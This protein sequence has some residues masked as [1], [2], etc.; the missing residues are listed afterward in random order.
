M[1]GVHVDAKARTA[2]VQGGCTW[3]D[4]DRETQVF[5]LAA[6]GG[7]VSTTGVAGL[8]LG[9]GLGYLRRKHGLTIDN[10]ISVD[11]V[12]VDGALRTASTVEN[13]ELFWGIRGGGGNFG[14][15]TSFEF[16]LHPVGP[17]V[18]LCNPWY[19][20]DDAAAILSKFAAIMK[21]APDEFS[22]NFFFWTIPAVV[23]FPE[24]HHGKRVA[25]IGGVHSGSLEE[26]ARFIQPLREL[27]QPLLDMSG[28]VPWTGVQAAFDPF[29][30]KREAP[31]LLQVTLSRGSRSR[32]DR[33]ASPTRDQRSRGADPNCYLEPRRRD[34]TG[35]K[36]GHSVSGAR[37]LVYAQRGLHLG[38]SSQGLRSHRLC[39]GVSARNGAILAG[40]A[41][42]ELRRPG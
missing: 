28:P 19:A 31:V 42:C 38:R 21:T 4:V 17:M 16:R 20:V 30:P 2:R 26:G 39:P 27:G 33:S 3:G 40:R 1:R 10:L 32:H 23:G 15:V 22:A 8:T 24:E 11:I 12:T 6:P 9:G 37:A 13:S 7:V 14:V 35:A 18:T 34:A 5:G 41:V 25:L 36:R 29:F